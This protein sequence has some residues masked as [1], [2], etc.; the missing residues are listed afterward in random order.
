MSEELSPRL[1]KQVS[2]T[3]ISQQSRADAGFAHAH[4]RKLSRQRRRGRGRLPRRTSPHFHSSQIGTRRPTADRL[5]RRANRPVRI[6]QRVLA[7]QALRDDVRGQSARGCA[8]E[9]RGL[10]LLWLLSFCSRLWSRRSRRRVCVRD[11]RDG[12]KVHRAGG[13]R[14]ALGVVLC[15]CL[16]VLVRIRRSRVVHKRRARQRLL[17]L[18]LRLR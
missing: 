3:L 11:A 13:I 10:L 14:P 2:I 1:K 5:G 7:L 12:D 8:R 18:W 17:F 9:R 4:L 16:H 6:R 15:P